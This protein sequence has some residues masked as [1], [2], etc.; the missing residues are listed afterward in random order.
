LSYSY[1]GN[2][3]IIQAYPYPRRQPIP[4]NIKFIN[5]ENATKYVGKSISKAQIA[6]IDTGVDYDHE[7]LTKHTLWVNG[8]PNNS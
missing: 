3:S 1:N 2:F 4:W 6:I 7:D 8:Y 5:A